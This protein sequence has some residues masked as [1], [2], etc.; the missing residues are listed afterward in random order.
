MRNADRN[1]AEDPLSVR[2]G[3]GLSIALWTS[4]GILA[5]LFVFSGVMKFVMP[6]EQ[7]TKQIPVSGAFVHFIG[8][9]ELLGGIGLIVPALFRI[10]PILTPIAASGLVIIMAGATV[11]TIPMGWIAVIPFLIGVIALFI[12]YGRF[13]LK[14]VQSRL[15]PT[16]LL[17]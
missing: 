1:L 5:A 3:R 2:R 4:Q 14:P 17:S 6:V 7:M 12:A 15:L 13:R 11:F 9:C 8:V 10:W 16:K